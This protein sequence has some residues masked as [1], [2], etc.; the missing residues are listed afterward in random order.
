MRKL[1][2]KYVCAGKIPPLVGLLPVS[3]SLTQRAPGPLC[4]VTNTVSL[5]E[6]ETKAFHPLPELPRHIHQEVG[7]N[8]LLCRSEYCFKTRTGTSEHLF[9]P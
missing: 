1:L 2:G 4:F 6:G 8:I 7:T 9:S 5:G 3:P